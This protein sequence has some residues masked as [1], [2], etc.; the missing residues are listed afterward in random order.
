VSN[1]A[2]QSSN[3]L[4]RD[5]LGLVVHAAG[6]VR[7]ESVPVKAPSPEEAL[8]QIAYGGICGSD[9][10]YWRHGAA[11]ESIVREPMVL[12]HEVVGTV[13]QAASDGS[14]PLAG[15]PVTVRPAIGPTGGRYLGS[16]AY[17]PHTQGVFARYVTLPASMLRALPE[18]LPLRTA[19]LAE[20]ASV[21]WHAVRR[22]GDI[23]DRSVAVIGAGPIGA[24]IIGVLRRHGAGEITAIDLY[25]QP[26]ERAAEMGA[27]RCVAAD[28]ADEISQLDVEITFEVSGSRPG[29]SS[30][31][32]ATARG[33][34]VVMVGLL[35][36][37]EQPVPISRAIAR[38]LEL[39]GSF[40]FD[41]EMT[42]VIEALADGSL[43]VEPIITDEFDLTDALRALE[44]AGDAAASGKVLLKF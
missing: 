5:A 36:P 28:H 27:T 35:P 26:L 22:A 24:L 44:V 31:I 8:V 11:G 10:H 17:L 19:A 12:G 38:E 32:A 33:G 9:I 15:T 13:A 39:V 29:L 37:G 4:P 2:G 7:V 18:T 14:G 40:R 3:L 30:A 41:D 43:R 34:R 20:P 42:T 16:A 21:A 25:P 6:D 23:R 1:S